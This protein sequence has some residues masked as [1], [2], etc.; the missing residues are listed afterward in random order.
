MSICFVRFIFFLFLLGWFCWFWGV[1]FIINDL[2]HFIHLNII[3]LN[4][5]F[6][7]I[8]CLIKCLYYLWSLFLL[9]LLWLF[10]IVM[11][12]CLV[13]WILFVLLCW[14]W[15]T[16][17]IIRKTE[18]CQI[19]VKVRNLN[20]QECPAGGSRVVAC[21]RQEEASCRFSQLRSVMA[22]CYVRYRTLC[23]WIDLFLLWH[24]VFW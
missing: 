24:R 14:F 20:F 19:S 10:F 1:Y 12:I 23:S 13:I 2:V 9:F 11:I 16:C 15:Y 5:I 3:T 7:M 21:G 18:F 17:T 4:G 6:I 8:F 22:W